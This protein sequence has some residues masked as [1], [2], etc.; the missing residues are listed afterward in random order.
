MTPRDPM[1]CQDSQSSQAVQQHEG[2]LTASVPHVVVITGIGMSAESGRFHFRDAE[3]GLC[4][5]FDPAEWATTQAWQ[6]A[7]AR[8]WARY[9]WRR[10]KVMAAQPSA[11][12][13]ALAALEQKCKVTV[14]TQNVDDLHE[15]AGSTKVIHLQGSLFAPRCIACHQPGQFASDPMPP[16]EVLGEIDPPTC[17]HCGSKIRPGV[18]WFGESL[19]EDAWR[20]ATEALAAADVLLIVGCS[21]AL[22][23]AAGLPMIAEERGALYVVIDPDEAPCAKSYFDQLWRAN[24]ADA[25]DKILELL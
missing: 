7:Q 4:K 5:N 12:H 11:G 24:P 17:K 20:Q 14:I 25:L 8:L 16:D 15:R 18:V 21:G 9:E 22:E 13:L 10:A 1:A 2:Q 3:H 23:T 19:S 6:I